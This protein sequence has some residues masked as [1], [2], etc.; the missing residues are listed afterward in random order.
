M[1]RSYRLVVKDTGLS[2]RQHGFESRWEYSDPDGSTRS[3]L[4]G[5]YA[6]IAQLVEHTHGKREVAGSIPAEGSVAVAQVVEHLVVAQEVA[7][8]TPVSHPT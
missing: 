8:S 2:S 3:A 7:G 1:L 5:P 4:A 6:L